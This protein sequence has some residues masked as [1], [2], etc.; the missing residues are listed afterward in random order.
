VLLI[1]GANGYTG[2]LIVDECLRR[3]LR[4]VLAARRLASIESLADAHALEARAFAL[5]DPTAVARAL[6][7]VRLVLHAAGP[8]VRTSEPMVTAC[9]ARQV[10][11][12]DITG[13][14]AV[15]ERCRAR[16][17]EAR[18]RGIVVLPGVGFDVVPTDCLAARLASALPGATR[19]ELGLAG[20][21]STSR[22]T[23]KT[24]VLGL[25]DG[26]AIREGGRIVRV[27]AAWKTMGLPFRD[28]TRVGVTIP[29]G[30]VSTAHWSTAIPDIHVY[31]ALP[32]GARRTLRMVGLFVPLLR[33]APVRRL[34]ERAIDAFVTG[35]TPEVRA[36]ARMQLWGRVTHP[37]GRVLEGT[38]ETPEG[39]RFTAM[40]AVES[41]RRVLDR[42]GLAGYQTPSSAFSAG[43]L[44]SLPECALAL[45]TVTRG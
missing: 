45:G 30:D 19:L 21:G 43:F 17:A 24:M 14:I 6:E 28:R 11:Y 12:L 2:R 37:D 39:Y 31:L 27:P 42:P 38:A 15:F 32:S 33:L 8:F 35:P 36:N 13:E 20:G 5:D 4:P 41:A 44:E 18:A 34:A 3:G 10:H 22:G 25:P 23:L 7:G 29:W 16:D 26:G 1:Y 9:L 40:A